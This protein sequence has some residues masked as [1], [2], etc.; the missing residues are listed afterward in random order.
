MALIALDTIKRLT[1]FGPNDLRL[2]G[3]IRPSWSAEFHQLWC[4]DDNLWPI[5]LQTR[6]VYDGIPNPQE[7]AF[8]L[9]WIQVRYCTRAY[10]LDVILYV[11]SGSCMRCFSKV[12]W[13]LKSISDGYASLI[14]QGQANIVF[15]LLL[16]IHQTANVNSARDTA[17]P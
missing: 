6:N 9:Y 11:A 4:D 15:S 12:V 1:N 8:I 13:L 5:R 3:P 17:D 7:L 16:S 10:V 14:A 2:S